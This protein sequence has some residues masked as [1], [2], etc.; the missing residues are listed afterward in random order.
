MSTARRYRY[1]YAEY[2]KLEAESPLKLEYSDGEIFAMAGGTP[3]HGALAMQ[4]V[5]LISPLLP[6][7][8]R[9]FSSD[10]K[11]R[12]VATDLGTYPDVSVVCGAIER[13]S[14][15]PNALTNPRF[16]IEVTSPSTEDY[17]RGDK[18]SQYK[19]LPSLEAMFLVS[20]RRKQVTM[21]RRRGGAWEEREIRGGEQVPFVDDAS[22]SVDEL[23]SVVE[24]LG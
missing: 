2:L 7:E 21:V 12:V 9:V 1:T 6:R 3:E 5:R 17:D 8:C 4:F 22:I 19:Q 24:Q 11:I 13:A 23:Y 18:V 16:L 10:V 14:D 15:D 20:H